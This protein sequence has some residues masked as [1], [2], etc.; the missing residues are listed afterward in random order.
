MHCKTYL[1]AACTLAAA[2]CGNGAGNTTADSATAD[3]DADTVMAAHADSGTSLDVQPLTGYFVKNNIQVSDSLTF[4]II[5]NPA[6]FDS[7][8]GMAKTMNNK[9]DNPDFGTH[10]VVAATMPATFYGTEIQ[11]AS[12]T[13]DD[14]NN[15]E[16]HFVAP[17]G[18]GKSSSSATPLWLGSI[19]KTGKSTIKLYTGDHLTKTVNELE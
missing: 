14:Q 19:P 6:T 5:D 1:L 17:A 11:L 3:S 15:A 13:S 9:I 7:L 16:L 10:V 8:F 2:S 4:W 18:N 12:A